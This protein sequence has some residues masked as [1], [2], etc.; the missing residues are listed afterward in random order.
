ME[1]IV[2]IA[3]V[4]P[5]LAFLTFIVGSLLVH[6]REV[7]KVH[8]AGICDRCNCD[9]TG[10]TSGICPECGLAVNDRT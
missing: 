10:N 3:M 8:R 1:L 9:L 7:T 6:H 2:V 5:G 4:L